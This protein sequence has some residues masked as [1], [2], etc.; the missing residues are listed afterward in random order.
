MRVRVKLSRLVKVKQ[1]AFF[2]IDSA[3]DIEDAKTKSISW[4]KDH[5]NRWAD[6][7]MT[8]RP[9]YTVESAEAVE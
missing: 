5:T 2:D 9:R 7:I 3:D 8:I 6:T 4:A 1:E